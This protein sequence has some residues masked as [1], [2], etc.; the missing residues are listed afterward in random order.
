MAVLRKILYVRKSGFKGALAKRKGATWRRSK[1]QELKAS[2]IRVG[3]ETRTIT[4]SPRD[5][6]AR[7]I[8]HLSK[9][10][11]LTVDLSIPHNCSNH[12]YSCYE[13]GKKCT[14][15]L[16]LSTFILKIS[17]GLKSVYSRFIQ[18]KCCRKCLLREV[19]NNYCK[20]NFI[21]GEDFL[22]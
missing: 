18:S 16:N 7:I 3:T 17:G 4:S 20:L 11:I 10:A 19:E 14:L 12:F 9:M 1:L 8:I 5:V 21:L 2:R 6:L 22:L 13:I 15:I